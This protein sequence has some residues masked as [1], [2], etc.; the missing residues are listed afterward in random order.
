MTLRIE[1]RVHDFKR[2]L[3]V[4]DEE[5]SRVSSRVKI[6]GYK[7]AKLH[8]VSKLHAYKSHLGDPWA[9]TST[10]PNFSQLIAGLAIERQDWGVY[11]MMF[12]GVFAA[13][14][15]SL[16]SMLVNPENDARFD[17]VRIRLLGYEYS[18]ALTVDIVSHSLHHFLDRNS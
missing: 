16:S 9:D 17:L 15:V 5:N 1:D 18:S 14:L 13:V 10:Q 12:Q 7:V 3:Y 2:L 6:P 8:T 11:I 4:A